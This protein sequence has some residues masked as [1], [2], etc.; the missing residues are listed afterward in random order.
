MLCPRYLAA[1]I[2]AR[3]DTR[4]RCAVLC[5]LLICGAIKPSRGEDSL[6]SGNLLQGNPSSTRSGKHL[7]QNTCS[8]CHG[9]SGEGGRGPKL[10]N[11]AQI[12]S[13]SDAELFKIIRDGIDGTEMPAFPVTSGQAWQLI[14]FIRSLNNTQIQQDARG[15]IGKGRELFFGRSGC[16]SCHMIH[17]RGGLLGPDLSNVAAERSLAQ[18][19]DSIRRPQR[20]AG[21]GYQ[22]VRLVAMDERMI[23]GIVKN[24]ST[25]SIQIMT[26]NGDLDFFSKNDLKAITYYRESMMPAATLSDP[27]F[28]DILAFLSRQRVNAIPKKARISGQQV[29]VDR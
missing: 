21:P 23:D 8:I 14:T 2:N 16:S 26:L 5:V 12:L 24:D 7:F 20:F 4:F 1:L 3:F 19:K 15:D 9:I 11:S 17:G 29:K 28:Q 18:V 22:H 10:A 25:Y 6:A 13:K 27:E